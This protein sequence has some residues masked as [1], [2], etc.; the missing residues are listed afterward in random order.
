MITVANKDPKNMPPSKW[1]LQINPTFSLSFPF[2]C[3]GAKI[4]QVVEAIPLVI[5]N[6][7]MLITLNWS[8]PN[9][10]SGQYF[11]WIKIKLG[12]NSSLIVDKIIIEFLLNRGIFPAM[13]LPSVSKTLN[14]VI[15]VTLNQASFFFP[16]PKTVKVV[17]RLVPGNTVKVIA[18]Q[19]VIC[20]AKNHVL[21]YNFLK[22][23][24][25]SPE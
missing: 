6:K 7:T 3:L 13:Y 2:I 1:K 9:I 20:K 15:I 19:I 4:N 23:Q 10:Q 5:A 12:I 25:D 11:S 16:V 8:D 14:I 17:L 22:L 24:S 18:K 21:Q